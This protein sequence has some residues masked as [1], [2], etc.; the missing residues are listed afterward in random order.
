MI[1]DD[2][3]NNI[4]IMRKKMREE[5]MFRMNKIVQVVNIKNEKC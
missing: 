2:E 4:I 1:S 3:H 5:R